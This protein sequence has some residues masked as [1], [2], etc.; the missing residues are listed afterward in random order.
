M[1]ALQFDAVES[2]FCT[3]L[4][5]GDIASNDVVN[6]ALSDCFRY[7]AK[8]RVGNCTRCPY[9]KPAVHAARLPSVV[10]DLRKNRCAV[11][12]YR[13][14]DVAVTRYDVSVEAVDEFFVW[15]VGGMR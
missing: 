4:G 15:P 8:E 11:L 13:R 12:V 9:R 6:I 10:V 7:F 3:I 2:A 14:C 5:N 1:A